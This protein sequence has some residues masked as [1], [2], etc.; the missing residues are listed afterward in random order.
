MGIKAT[1]NIMES[2]EALAREKERFNGEVR[3]LKG[4]EKIEVEIEI[5]KSRI[6][7]VENDRKHL[8]ENHMFTQKIENMKIQIENLK[9]ELEECKL[10]EKSLEVKV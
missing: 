10:R 5:I 2:Q 8:G 1:K 7:N 9:K 4:T 3:K 6:L